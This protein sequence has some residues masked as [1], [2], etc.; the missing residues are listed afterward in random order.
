MSHVVFLRGANT[1]G[2][3]VFQPTQVARTLA[4]HDVVNVG[5]A[6]TFVVR[7][8]VSQATI[9]RL[10]T[11]ALPFK[12]D[13]M[14]CPAIELLELLDDDAFDA[15]SP[16]DA[17]SY[18]TIMVAPLKRTPTLPIAQP[19]G[20]QWCVKIVAIRGRY[21]RSLHRRMGTR[22]IYP[23]EVV[24]KQF[25]QPATTRKW[26]TILKLAEILRH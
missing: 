17:N 22:L 4:E 3:K 9:A 8:S 15:K 25:R 10:F 23:N 2:Q 18:L 12:T 5:A 24:E 7:A 1:G 16:K 11:R 13:L 6:G 26:S 20:N 21:V 19:E 14:I